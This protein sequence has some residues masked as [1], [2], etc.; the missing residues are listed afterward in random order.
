MIDSLLLLFIF[1]LAIK[2]KVQYIAN[3]SYAI[4]ASKHL[5]LNELYNIKQFVKKKVQ[6]NFDILFFFFK[7]LV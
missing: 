6:I 5:M 2:K 7:N 4:Y 3:K 1:S